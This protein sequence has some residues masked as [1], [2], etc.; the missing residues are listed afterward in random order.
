MWWCKRPSAKAAFFAATFHRRVTDFFRLRVHVVIILAGLLAVCSDPVARAGPSEIYTWDRVA[1]GG[2]GYVTGIVAHPTER[3]LLYIRTDNGG[4]YRWDAPTDSWI[5]ITNHWTV[6]EKNYYGIDG[7]AIDP[8]NPNVVY[9]AAGKNIGGIGAIFKSN[10]RGHSWSLVKAVNFAGNGDLRWAG[11]PIAVDPRNSSIVYVGTRQDGLLRTTDGGATWATI[12]AVPAGEGGIG[13]RTVAIDPREYVHFKSQHI[14]VGVHGIGVYISTNGGSNWSLM[15]GSPAQPRRMNVASNGNLYVTAGTG[16]FRYSKNVW[17]DVSPIHSAFAALDVAG[18]NPDRLV[19]A[20]DYYGSQQRGPMKTPIYLSDTGGRTWTEVVQKS[21]WQFTAAWYSGRR[22]SAA[23]SDLQFDPQNSGQV[24]LADWYQVMV[25][26]NVDATAPFW[27]QKLKGH[28]QLSV[29]SL[30]APAIGAPL[31]SGLADNRGFRHGSL[32]DYPTFGENIAIEPTG[33]DFSEA[34]PNDLF[35]VGGE[36]KGIAAYSSDNG[37]SW[38]KTFWPFG[39]NGKVAVSATNSNLV[40]VVPRHSTPKRSVSRGS[41]WEETIGA[42]AGGVTDFWSGQIPIASDRVDGNVFYYLNEN[43]DFY[44][45]ID[46]GLLWVIVSTLQVQS[47][48]MVKAAPGIRSEVWVS[49]V[50]RGLYHSSDGGDT[51][52]RIP[53]VD[54]ALLFTFGKGLVGKSFPAVFLYGRVLGVAGIFRSE[55][56]GKTWMKI[57]DGES[58]VGVNPKVMEGDRQVFGRVYIGTGGGGIFYGTP[59]SW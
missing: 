53:A 49:A 35:E 37:A 42:A 14:Y 46:G 13:I 50:D 10:D 44:R 34:N 23:T 55:D 58:I 21:K 52:R 9:V 36:I 19:V 33:I 4:A 27:V 56:M 17:Q 6:A 1:I 51:F 29:L 12:S 24:W 11:E 8:L 31:I 22:F 3:N 43:G 39:G 30:S 40:V 5:W 7:I 28:E 41:T 18:D 2:G 20:T 57:N 59:G 15:H 38:T 47:G 16:V 25:T 48:Y 26:D 54:Q 45:S 32:Q